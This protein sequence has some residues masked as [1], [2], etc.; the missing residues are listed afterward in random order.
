M[1]ELG[2]KRGDERTN[3]EV[4]VTEVTVGN[5]DCDK[6]Q[7]L[8]WCPM[9]HFCRHLQISCWTPCSLIHFS[10]R[11]RFMLQSPLQEDVVVCYWCTFLVLLS[12]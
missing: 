9:P 1:E 12:T 7:K 10:G 6:M 5:A 2:R 3:W 11:A 4:T 8:K